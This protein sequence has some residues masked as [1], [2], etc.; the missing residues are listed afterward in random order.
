VGALA[1]IVSTAAD[2]ATATAA[3]P[4]AVGFLIGGWI[5][6]S[7]VRHLPARGLRLFIGLCGLGVAIRL[8]VSAYS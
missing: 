2:V 4:L 8:A 3:L 1:G 6:P 5:G 7:P